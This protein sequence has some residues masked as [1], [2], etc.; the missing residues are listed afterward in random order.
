MK[1]VDDESCPCPLCT[2]AVSG[3]IVD[4][5]MASAAEQGPTMT[6]EEFRAWLGGVR[7]EGPDVTGE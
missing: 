1:A 5:V 7:R 6:L 2:E 3:E 4:L